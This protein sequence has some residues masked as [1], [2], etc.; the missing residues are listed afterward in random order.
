[1]I[2]ASASPAIT[3]TLFVL[4]VLSA[5]Y[6]GLGALFA[7]I[8]AL[9]VP[10]TPTLSAKARIM[11]QSNRVALGMI[12]PGVLLAGIFGI[13]LTAAQGDSL[14]QAWLIYSLILYAIALVMGG[15]SGPISARL[16]RQVESEARSGKKPSAA[17]QQALR[18][19]VPL[20]LTGITLLVTVLLVYLMFAQP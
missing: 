16:R 12:V 5:S 9:Q 13:A 7:T 11:N 17:L 8:L 4:H 14:K 3:T 20:I 2:L 10:N 15:V 18:S 6:F 1:M 19:P